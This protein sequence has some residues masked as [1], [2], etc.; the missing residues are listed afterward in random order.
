[1]YFL[2]FIYWFNI[3]LLLWSEGSTI[4]LY[5]IKLL[6]KVKTFRDMKIPTYSIDNLW[7]NRGSIIVSLSKIRVFLDPRHISVLCYFVFCLTIKKI[8]WNIETYTSPYCSL[9][10]V[11]PANLAGVVR[12]NSSHY[13]SHTR[14]KYGYIGRNFRNKKFSQNCHISFFSNF[15]RKQL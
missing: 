1:M 11:K 13:E 3:N 12:S 2:S 10:R 9:S 14:A 6:F 4:Q 15:Y 7:E 5:V 8:S